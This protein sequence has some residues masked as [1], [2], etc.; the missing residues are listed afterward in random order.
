[1]PPGIQIPDLAQL[2]PG[3]GAG[4]GPALQRAHPHFYAYLRQE[5]STDQSGEEPKHVVEEVFYCQHCLAIVKIRVFEMPVAQ[6]EAAMAEAR[7]QMEIK[8]GKPLS[9]ADALEGERPEGM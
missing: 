8:A 9:L 6:F 5:K 7:R 3:S 1:M 2:G 4:G